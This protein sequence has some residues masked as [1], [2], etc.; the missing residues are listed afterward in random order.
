LRDG[1]SCQILSSAYDAHMTTMNIS[2]PDDM[3]AFVDEQVR[4]HGYMSSSEY[5]R[6]LIR[7]Q[8]DD[9]EKLRAMIQE[10]ID[11]GTAGTAEE[12]TAR[13]RARIAAYKP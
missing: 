13:L 11:S 1:N 2:L 7:Q 5:V 4:L 10:G 9:I 6:A 3:K 12:V 8:K